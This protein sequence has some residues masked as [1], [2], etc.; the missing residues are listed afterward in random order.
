MAYTGFC[1]FGRVV[2]AA[3]M[4]STAGCSFTESSTTIRSAPEPA[5]QRL[6]LARADSAPLT[7]QF[8]QEGH[9]IV[10]QLAF[11]N[12]CTAESTQVVK[13]QEVTER[14]TRRGTVGALVAVGAAVAAVG[15]GFL[16]AS[17]SAD[18]RVSCGEGKAG[19]TC[20]S[21][22]SAEQYLGATALGYGLGSAIL[23]G[24]WLAQKPQVESKE[25]PPEQLTH[26]VPG[27]FA[28]GTTAALEGL[29]LAVDL[30]NNGKWTGRVSAD[31]AV[32]IDINEKIT[33][34]D[35]TPVRVVVESVPA[36]LAGTVAVGASWGLAPRAASSEKRLSAMRP[37]TG[38][39]R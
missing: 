13:R 20:D 38:R 35:D 9:A 39:G 11:A 3:L 33:L 29:A 31:G 26:P 19:D 34:N 5:T 28:C 15:V 2:A 36:S 7:G 27:T 30:P 10:G 14:H 23:G 8:H 18:K 22:S 4:V 25:L 21:E 12:D 17:A 24:Y 32:R 1:C 37:L 6:R 16:V